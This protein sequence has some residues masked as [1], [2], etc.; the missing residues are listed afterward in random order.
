M[1]V[2]DLRIVAADDHVL[3]LQGLCDY[4][5]AKGLNV[6]GKANNGTEALQL[7]TDESPDLAILDV[8]MPYLSGF[9]IAEICQ[10][11]GLSTK[12]M[13]LSLHDDTDFIAQAKSAG[14]SGYVLKADGPEEV[15]KCVEA[16]SAGETYFHFGLSDSASGVG[17]MSKISDLTQSERKILRF[18]AQKNSNQ[19]IAEL[20]FISERTVEKHRSNIVAKLGLP[21]QSNSLTSW[22]MENKALLNNL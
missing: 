13:I 22:A 15:L 11:K 6:V 1:K 17:T 8:E 14:V 9:S 21:G 7:I 10:Q 3:L 19:Q 5:T 2:T 16:I 18:V 4:L 12:I 20:L